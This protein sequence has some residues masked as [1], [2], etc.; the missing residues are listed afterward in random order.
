MV[1]PC[2]RSTFQNTLLKKSK[3]ETTGRRR[4]K[5][6]LDDL[7]ETRG[8]YIYKTIF[9]LI[10]S[11]FYAVNIMLSP[12]T[13]FCRKFPAQDKS[14][15]RSDSGS[16][17]WSQTLNGNSESSKAHQTNTSQITYGDR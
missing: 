7:K 1:T 2:V 6:L 13:K 8:V 16:P 10:H 11:T 9:K 17:Q 5:H 4:R 14:L 15:G 3:E 12:E